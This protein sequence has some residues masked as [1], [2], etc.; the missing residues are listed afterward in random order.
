MQSNQGMH[1]SSNS[2][3]KSI[4][5]ANF[6]VPRRSLDINFNCLLSFQSC[7]LKLYTLLPLL[8]KDSMLKATHQQS[9]CSLQKLKLLHSK[10]TNTFKCNVNFQHGKN[11]TGCYQNY[12]I[13]TCLMQN[14][15]VWFLLCFSH[16]TAIN[17]VYLSVSQSV[18]LVMSSDMY[19]TCSLPLP[20][21][22]T[23]NSMWQV[24]V[25]DLFWQAEL[26]RILF[27]GFFL[28][29]Y[30]EHLT[31][32]CCVWSSKPEVIG[33]DIIISYFWWYFE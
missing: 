7:D 3:V 9:E 10:K 19:G 12:H 18:V 2:L 29:I 24:A 5:L 23:S 26:Q 15:K 32:V 21:S 14:I 11:V 16:T 30:P 6:Q 17:N 13:A 31:G 4:L 25:E 22:K 33:D 27:A 20:G 28:P 8:Q 1:Y